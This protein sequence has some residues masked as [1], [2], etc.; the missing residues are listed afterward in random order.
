MLALTILVACDDSAAAAGGQR[1]LAD[2]AGVVGTR[3]ELAPAEAPEEAPLVLSIGAEAW[4]ARVGEDWET[5]A[6]VGNWAVTVGDALTLDDVPVLGT[7]LPE[8]AE[9]VTWY[10]TFPEAVSVTVADEPF[11]GEW[12]FAPDLGPVVVTLDGV[13]RECVFYER[14]VAEDSGG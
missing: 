4:E 11:A 12:S 10:G 1:Q 5:A 13:R 14:E 7:P 6:A 3:I 9:L 2:Y 8:A